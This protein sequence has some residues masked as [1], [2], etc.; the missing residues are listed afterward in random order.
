MRIDVLLLIICVLIPI[1]HLSILSYKK[2]YLSTKEVW[3]IWGEILLTPIWITISVYLE[4]YQMLQ[5][6]LGYQLW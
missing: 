2:K 3:F 4:G 5:N 6:V 1:V